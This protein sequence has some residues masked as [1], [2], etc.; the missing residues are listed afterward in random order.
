MKKVGQKMTKVALQICAD[1]GEKKKPMSSRWDGAYIGTEHAHDANAEPT[2]PPTG[3]Q[4]YCSRFFGSS[5]MPGEH[6]KARKLQLKV[7]F[8]NPSNWASTNGEG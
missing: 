3:V 5:L 1:G 4:K 8:R 2:M 6:S 7:C